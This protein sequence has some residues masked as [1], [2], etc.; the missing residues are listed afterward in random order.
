MT[1]RIVCFRQARNVARERVLVRAAIGRSGTC[2]WVALSLALVLCAVAPAAFGA[3]PVR[4][5]GAPGASSVAL[6][7]PLHNELSYRGAVGAQHRQFWYRFQA[8][9][10]RRAIL[11]VWSTVGSCP[12]RVTMLDQ[13]RHVLAQTITTHE[14]I[15][16]FVVSLRAR[17][18]A[19]PFYVRVD[20]SPFGSSCA[21]SAY[22]LTI[23][24]PQQPP[25]CQAPP[26]EP[27]ACS[28]PTPTSTTV[29]AS[30]LAPMSRRPPTYAHAP[31][32]NS[33]GSRCEKAGRELSHAAVAAARERRV[34]ARGGPSRARLRHLEAVRHW[35]RNQT[36]TSCD[37]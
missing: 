2:A 37:L 27:T 19:E 35:W 14:E 25:A 28:P 33:A 24:E 12:V 11:E 5:A 36:L 8:G 20:A 9:G 18:A 16:P 7:T 15:L 31:S 29:P 13:R 1:C 30:T 10:A 17:T 23:V 6:A 32:A 34:V 22:V 4:P 3:A 21:R 26:T